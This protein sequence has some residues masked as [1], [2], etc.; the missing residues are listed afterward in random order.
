MTSNHD[1]TEIMTL[2]EVAVYL[3]LAE[4]TV[5]RMAQRGKIPAAKIASQWRFMRSVIRDW[6]AGQMQMMP[7]S[8]RSVPPGTGRM[9]LDPAEMI[10][11][12]LMNLHLTPGPKES[13]LRQIV[14][15][16]R[17]SGFAKDT[18][19]LLAGLI[20]RERMMTTAVG[21]GLAIPHPRKPIERLFRE[22]AIAFGLCP[23]GT[24]FGA[25]DDRLVHLFFLICATR[26]EVHLQLMASVSWLTRR[27]GLPARL[28]QVSSAQEVLEI[29]SA[30]ESAEAP[31][32]Q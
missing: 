3:Q 19:G 32:A 8:Q 28:K 11:P 12:E 26:E 17:D 24:N 6:L 4:K 23:E 1:E 9:P 2:Q 20:E 16:L 31:G 21:H 18:G 5:L 22:P 7:P 30:G 27:E 13:I 25:V 10:R 29:V 14:K 15:P